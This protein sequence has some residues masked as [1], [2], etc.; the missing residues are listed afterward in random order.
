MNKAIMYAWQVHNIIHTF[1][2]QTLTASNESLSDVENATTHACAPATQ[3]N[4][5]NYIAI[6]VSKDLFTRN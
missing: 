3:Q 5:K 2:F 1:F 6:W 4:E